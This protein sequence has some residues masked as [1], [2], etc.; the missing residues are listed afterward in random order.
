VH[1]VV[2]VALAIACGATSVSASPAGQVAS[3]QAAVDDA[4]AEYD[5]ASRRLSAIETSLAANSV[6]LDGLVSRQTDL[7]TRL[8]TRASSMYRTGT[9]GFL[10]VLVGSSTFDQFLTV[11]DALLRFNRQDID[12]I[13]QLKN[14]RAQVRQSSAQ[15]LKQEE[16]ASRRLR[17]LEAAKSQ[18]ARTLAKDQAAY[19]R[20]RGR[21]AAQEA[22]R[23]ASARAAASKRTASAASVPQRLAGSGEW[24]TAV[25]SMYGSGSYGIR[26]SSGV[27]IGPDS[28]IVAHKTLP[29][30]TLVEFS[31]NGHTAVAKVADRGPYVRGR[32]WDLGPGTARVLG[33]RGVGE[34]KYRVIGR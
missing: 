19:A 34:V 2:G 13:R 6:K 14:A 4:V 27:T 22:L 28:M 11:W 10:E 31:Y 3:S 18:A 26:L 1:L 15:L 33:F 24:K 5:A 32:E 17:A 30:G 23:A 25:A 12:T 16:E 29:F 8:G 9:L 7:E 21:I 20:Y